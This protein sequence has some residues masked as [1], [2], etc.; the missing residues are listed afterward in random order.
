[1]QQV[2]PGAKITSIELTVPTA[3][4]MAKFNKP[5]TMPDG[6]T[7]VMP[8]KPTKQL[9]IKAESKSASGSGTSSSKSPVA[10]VKGKLVIRFPCLRR[11]SIRAT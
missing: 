9:V 4:E 5:M 10:E 11:S 8:V 3:E 1:M 6:K 2:D 7:Y